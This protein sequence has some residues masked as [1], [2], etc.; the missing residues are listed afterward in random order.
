MNCGISGTSVP[1]STQKLS[2]NGLRTGMGDCFS[3]LLMYDGFVV[4]TG[5]PKPLSALLM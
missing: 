5:R 3:A 4:T 1:V 2:G